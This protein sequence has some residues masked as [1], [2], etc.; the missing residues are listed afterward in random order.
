MGRMR[1]GSG[2]A[3]VPAHGQLKEAKTIPPTG[4][5]RTPRALLALA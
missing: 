4:T 3:S 1:T 2:R 5:A